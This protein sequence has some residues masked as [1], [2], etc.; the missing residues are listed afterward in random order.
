[1]GEH[2]ELVVAGVVVAGVVAQWLGWRIGIP[3]IV[4]LLFFGIVVGPVTGGLR[5]DRLF[6]DLLF[7]FVSLAVAVVLFEGALGLGSR[8]LRHAGRTVWILL[9]VGAAITVAGIA[10]AARFVL[11]VDWGLALVLA[12]VLVVTGPTVIGPI[13]RTIGLKGRLAA[14]LEAEGTLIDPIGAILAVLVFQAVY[15]TGAG[16]DGIALGLIETLGVGAAFGAVAAALLVIGSARF[17]IPEELQNVTTLALVLGAFA[18]ANA[19]RDEAGLVAVTVMGIV[20]ASQSQVSVRHVLRFNATLRVL[21]VSSLFILLGASVEA[22][23]LRTLEWQ[24]LAFAAV[25]VVLVRPLSVLV[26]TVRSGFSR[27]E[28]T[29]LAAM[30]PRGIVAA[31]VASVFAL[32]LD[33]LRAGDSQVLVSATFTVIAVTVIVSGF[34]GPWLARR[35]GLIDRRRNAIVVLGASPMARAF[36]EAL[37]RHDI[38]VRVVSLDRHEINQARMEGLSAHRGSVFADDTWDAIE[39]DHAG[40]FVAMTANDELNV[41][42]SR[43][44]AAAL[45]RKHVFQLVPRRAEHAAWWTLQPGIFARPLFAAD[46]TFDVL[47]QRLEGGSKVT[48]TRLTPQFGADDYA[49]THPEAIPMF[50]LD[51]RGRVDLVT[52]DNE[53]RFGVGDLVGALTASGTGESNHT[54]EIEGAPHVGG[55]V[56]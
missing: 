42:A 24:N 28:R 40:V 20:L 53:F 52:A 3:A 48:V 34:G 49:A 19:I 37:S 6:G 14:V 56:S 38:P 1:L 36:A 8:R 15:E 33:E 30:A 7:P 41:L 26:S 23:T 27:S 11:D 9:T 10:L 47:Q 55:S 16:V 46:V 2:V 12:T 5:P 54:V 35:L 43:Y 21:L 25:L 45:G 39:L 50:R 32:R 22:D 17:L 18:V 51:E 4:F 44:A 31:A 29:F 13:V